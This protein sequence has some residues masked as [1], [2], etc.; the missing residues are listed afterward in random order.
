MT[1][2]ASL[3]SLLNELLIYTQSL[4]QSVADD[5]SEPEDWIELLDKRQE[6]MD[7]LS[8]IF[9]QGIQLTEDQK[10]N[11][12]QPVNDMD[13]KIHP[14]MDRKKKLLESEM[15]NM[16]KSKAVNQQYGEFGQ[17]YSPYGAFFDKK[18]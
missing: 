14:I 4:E 9:S 11:Y 12:L 6:V 7:S 13:L 17:S 10:K 5:E 18:K 1:I 15:L 8:S 16:N 2:S 3:D